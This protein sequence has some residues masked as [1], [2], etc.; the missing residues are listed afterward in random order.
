[1]LM[2]G[3]SAVAMGNQH[4]KIMPKPKTNLLFFQIQDICRYQNL[5]ETCIDSLMML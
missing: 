4:S 3:A 5:H 1:M 2:L